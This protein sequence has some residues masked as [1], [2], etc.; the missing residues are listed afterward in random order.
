MLDQFRTGDA[1]IPVEADHDVDRL[2]GI[3][4]RIHNVGA[5]APNAMY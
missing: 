5:W 3:S 2:A 4:R 1:A